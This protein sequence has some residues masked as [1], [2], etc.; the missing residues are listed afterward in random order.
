M[1]FSNTSDKTYV[2]INVMCVFTC[3]MHIFCNAP[4]A[5]LC[6][7]KKFIQMPLLIDHDGVGYYTLHWIIPNLYNVTL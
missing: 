5:Y 4:E 2:N 6:N 1:T 3:I 7:K